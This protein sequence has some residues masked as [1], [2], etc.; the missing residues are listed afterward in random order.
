MKDRVPVVYVASPVIAAFIIPTAIH[1]HQVIILTAVMILL[2]FSAR[3]L[4]RSR[5]RKSVQKVIEDSEKRQG[6]VIKAAEIRKPSGKMDQK[7][8]FS[9][10]GIPRNSEILRLLRDH[11]TESKRHAI[12]TIGKFG[13]TGLMDEVC[14]CLGNPSLE[15][16]AEHV[17]G[18]FGEKAVL[19]LM[20]FYDATHENINARQCVLRI[21]GTIRNTESNSF[22]FN[23]LWSASRELKEVAAHSLESTGF[24]PAGP[25][26]EKLDQLISDVTGIIAWDTAA[27]ITLRRNR[28]TF[29]LERISEDLTRWQSFLFSLLSISYGHGHSE[30]IRLLIEEGSDASLSLAGG[31]IGNLVSPLV[32]QQVSAS[33]AIHSDNVRIKKLRRWFPGEILTYE[34]LCESVINRDYNLLDLWTKA[35][36]LRY[37]PEIRTPAMA[38]TASA[39]LFSPEEIMREE[40]ARL[41]ART[42]RELYWSVSERLADPIKRRLD[43]IVMGKLEQ[44]DLVFNK[45]AF[46]S[47]HLKGIPERHLLSLSGNMVFASEYQGTPLHQDCIIWPVKS[48]GHKA[49]VHYSLQKDISETLPGRNE[50]CYFLSLSSLEEFSNHSPGFAAEIMGYLGK[51]Q[52]VQNIQ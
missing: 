39:L 15:P 49:Y 3:Y 20:K 16:D 38:E 42:N 33:L 35:C 9:G 6:R 7:H 11:S 47:G 22:L 10:P 13:L 2:I 48:P 36:T 30:T 51:I 52:Q 44:E 23:A 19:P 26:R 8:K 29:L 34:S 12:Y 50:P 21:M 17:L 40:S 31:V 14:Q 41:M 5:F 24:V 18:A 4:L 32:S 1:A 25:E 45:V 27:M 43:T 46:L 37:M 28:D